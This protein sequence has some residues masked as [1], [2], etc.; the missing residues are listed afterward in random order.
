VNLKYFG[1]EVLGNKTERPELYELEY[2]G[3]EYDSEPSIYF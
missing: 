3:F 2:Y 1:N